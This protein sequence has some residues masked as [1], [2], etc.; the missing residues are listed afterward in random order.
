MKKIIT[1][2]VIVFCLHT[3]AQTWVTI[4]D[5]NFASYLQSIIPSAMSGNQMNTSSTLVTTTTHAI[6]VYNKNITDLNGIQ[7]F[8]S[9]TSLDCSYN[10]LV[11]LPALPN[12]LTILSCYNNSLLNLPA[13]PN[14]LTSLSC[15][16]N[17]LTSLPNLPNS[18]NRLYC[19]WNSI[20]SLPVLPNTLQYLN[21]QSNSLTNL[22]VLPNT[23]NL[24]ICDSN[25]ITCFPVF[26]NSIN[27]ASFTIDP[28]P[29]TCLPNYISAMNSTDL[30][31]PLCTIGD[32]SGCTVA[33][34]EE[35]TN[36]TI[37]ASIYP[38]PT[39]NNFTIE[40]NTAN[41]QTLQIFDVNGKVVLNQTLNGKTNV[42]CSTL[43]EG[44]YN[45]SL[46]SNEGIVNKRLVIVK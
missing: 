29:Y 12:S 42:D 6:N 2:C 39:S 13:L 33:G 3:K 11:N 21:C 34:I 17:S 4:P 14:S 16:S 20:T 43:S 41:K 44:V 1:L 46:I 24:L 30:A 15:M 19:E 40:L 36:S 28:N 32:G 38:N 25:K 31:K 18:L 9:L 27:I 23:L 5:A 26:P 10:S 8:S 35:I 37:Q 45:I 7:Y 22:P